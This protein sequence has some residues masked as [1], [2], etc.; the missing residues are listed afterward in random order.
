MWED[1]EQE[2][3]DLLAE[4]DATARRGYYKSLS[5]GL[6]GFVIAIA[7]VLGLMFY[8]LWILTKVAG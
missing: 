8:G 3:Q 5:W 6:M 2:E 1:I 4:S 7:C